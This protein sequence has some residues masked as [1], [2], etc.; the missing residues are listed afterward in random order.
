MFEKL[1][2]DKEIFDFTYVIR[3]LKIIWGAT[4]KLTIIRFTLTIFSAILPL[5]PY[6]LMKLLL[7]A[8]VDKENLPTMRYIMMIL[9]GFV[10]VK[11]TSIIVSQIAVYVNLLQSDI[12]ADHMSEIVINK[13][14]NTDLEYFDSDLYHDIFQRAIATSSGRPMQV[15]STITLLGQNIITLLSA[16]GVMLIYL[17]WGVILILVMIALPVALIKW[18]FTNKMI[19][20]KVA[21]TQKERKAGYFKGVLTSNLYAKEVRIFS[22]G[23]K[24]LRI[25][26]K[27]RKVLRD[28]KR[29]LYLKQTRSLGVGQAFE[30]ITIIAALGLIAH[31]AI[32]GAISVGDIAMFYGLFQKSQ[33]CVAQVLSSGVT[34]HEHRRYLEHLFTFLDLQ[35]KIVDP[36]QIIPIAEKVDSVSLKNVE[37]TYPG[38][39][40]KV[41]DDIT[42]DINKGQI[43][44]IVGEN[45]S[46]KTTLIKLITR[47]YEHDKGEIN[48]ND[49]SIKKYS[50]ESLR[51]KFTVIFQMF[52]KYN[53]TVTENVQ[54]AD[55][56]SKISPA[57]IKESTELAHAKGF[58]DELPAGYETAL[59]RSFRMGEELS[60]GQWQKIALSRAFY[61][62]AEVIILDE[63]TSFIDPLA[64]EDIFA[65][66]RKLS[67]DKILIL[68]THRIY[69]LKMADKII[70]MDKGKIVEQGNHEELVKKGGLFKEMFDKQ[71]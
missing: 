10:A 1:S 6:Y 67:K 61:K 51:S 31:R 58:I 16:L 28:E 32:V 36:P 11:L 26:L 18:F 39:N 56:N 63:P 33:G 5:I 8:F 7:D 64:E 42:V 27:L 41:I 57:R 15:L 9:L 38:T 40:K 50:L 53:A 70:V 48:I 29:R 13:T 54:F 12:I 22:F 44:A 24:L 55:M 35:P 25:F 20:L 21:Q 37:F 62:D 4:K 46:G 68:I 66:L 30:S 65:S 49:K 23:E 60:G 52:A 3:I 43:L 14:I 71:S 47:L 45:G 34:I 19:D 17:H 69:N 2:I 59:G